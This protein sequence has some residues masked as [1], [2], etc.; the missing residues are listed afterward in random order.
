ME[1]T[2]N[3]LNFGR[4]GLIVKRSKATSSG[5][6]KG[7]MENQHLRMKVFQTVQLLLH[8]IFATPFI[9][10]EKDLE[11][12]ENHQYFDDVLQKIENNMYENSQQV[13]EDLNDIIDKNH[14]TKNEANFMLLDSNGIGT[15]KMNYF[16][17]DVEIMANQMRKKIHELGETILGQASEIQQIEVKQDFDMIQQQDDSDK[18]Y[19]TLQPR[20]PSVP[21]VIL[22][23]KALEI[24]LSKSLDLK[25]IKEELE[26]TNKNFQP[27]FES[28]KFYPCG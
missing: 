6:L 27:K 26:E 21:A 22:M 11:S 8:H 7:S 16:H 13:F 28:Y 10:K 25:C 2:T 1:H 12:D 17:E 23:A 15:K 20:F 24:S 4:D 3:N 9:K 14:R 18:I 19:E 5:V